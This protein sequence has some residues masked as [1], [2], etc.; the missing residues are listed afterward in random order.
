MHGDSSFLENSYTTI[1]AST[2]SFPWPQ[3]QDLEKEFL[4]GTREPRLHTSEWRGG[5]DAELWEGQP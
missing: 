5:A 1:F 3:N 4:P 2:H